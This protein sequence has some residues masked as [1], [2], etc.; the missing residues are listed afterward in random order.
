M[1]RNLNLPVVTVGAVTASS[2]AI[3]WAPDWWCDGFQV[4]WGLH[5]DV[6]NPVYK[7]T[8]TSYV[9]TNLSPATSYVI[10]V[11]ETLSTN[12]TNPGPG[13]QVSVTTAPAP[14][15]TS[16]SLATAPGA[17]AGWTSTTFQA[18]DTGVGANGVAWFIAPNQAIFKV[19]AAGPVQIPGAAVRIAV[20][21]SGLPWVVNSAHQIFRWLGSSWQQ[22]PGAALDVG[23]GANG[24]VWIIDPVIGSPKSWDGAVWTAISGNGAQIS[25]DPSGNPWVT[26]ASHQVWRYMNNAWQQIPGSAQDI[27]IGADGT[28]YVVGMTSLAGGFGVYHWNAATNSWI[29]DTGVA[30]ITVSAG[31]TPAAYVA[32]NA[33]SGLPVIRK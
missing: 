6:S 5:N 23:I 17:P 27:G 9:I 11:A 2:I 8:G 19:T 15:P 24:K 10:V 7:T 13:T 33:A 4:T 22:M 26:N 20:D 1:N 31:P 16:T 3:S 21:P 28:V 32:R 30:G 12:I 29:A 25:V 18:L 14:A